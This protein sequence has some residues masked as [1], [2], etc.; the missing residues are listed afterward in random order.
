[1][2]SLK[3]AD[4]KHVDISCQELLFNVVLMNRLNFQIYTN[5]SRGGGFYPLEMYA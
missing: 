3:F 4:T 5:S 2:K 1:M